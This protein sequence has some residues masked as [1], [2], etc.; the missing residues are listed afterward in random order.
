MA[1]YGR[2]GSLKNVLLLVPFDL[3]F[4]CGPKILPNSKGFFWLRKFSK[5]VCSI[6]TL[7]KHVT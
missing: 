1:E 7:A 6:N 4:N 2:F 5:V 3:I